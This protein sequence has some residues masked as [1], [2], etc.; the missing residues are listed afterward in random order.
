MIHIMNLKLNIKKKII[1]L[2]VIFATILSGVA[3]FT[4]SRTITKMVDESYQNRTDEIAATVARVIDA[5]AAEKLTKELMSI[6]Y[7]IDDK[8]GSEEWGTPEF[9]AYVAKYEHLRDTEE[10][11]L[12]LKQLRSLQEVNSVDCIYLINVEFD[13]KQ[14]I[15]IVDAALE[16]ECPPGCF[17]P[18]YEVNYG[19][20]ENHDLGFPAYITNTE[21]Y[22]WLVTSAAPVYNGKGELVCYAAVDV[23]MDDIRK[24]QQDFITSLAFILIL[25]TFAICFITIRII[26]GSIVRPLN[27]LSEAA[28]KYRGSQSRQ[29]ASF[30]ELDIK[31]GDEIETLHRSMVQMEKDIDNYIE[32]LDKTRKQLSS[33]KQE[34]DEMNELAHKDSL[35]GIRNK[36]AYDQEEAKL[37]NEFKEGKKEFGIAIV[38]LNGLKFIND[39]YG[40]DCGNISIVT[41]SK[42]ICEVFLHSPVF[43]IGGDEF[44]IILKN[45]DYDKIDSLTAEFHQRLKALEKEDLEPW[46]KVSASIGY[47]LY[48]PKLDNSVD[49]VFRRADQDM[50][51]K[52][53]KMKE[54]R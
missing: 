9:D 25:M 38:D 11:K 32:N 33:T 35:T 27:M 18:L 30:N 37:R 4:S 54:D 10:F 26:D 16:D 39:N 15:Y 19:I 29:K 52:K 23:T 21:E 17:D 1:I 51:Q 47:A 7:S 13:N 45:N 50:Y 8:V 22:G 24:E 20:I 53:K 43:R 6:Y 36:L 12:L 44:A 42:I 41:I 40:H 48:D 3:L 28:L 31:T 2:I 49:D 46:E 34:A 5:D 14:F